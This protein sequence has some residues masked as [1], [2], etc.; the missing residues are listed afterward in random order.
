MQCRIAPSLGA[1][2]GHPNDVWGTTDYADNEIDREK[3][4][5]FFGLYGL[6][7]FYALWRHKGKK[8]ILWAGSDIQ[9]FINGYWLEEGGSIKVSHRPLATWIQK[10]CESWVENDVEYEALKKVGI[11]SQVCPSFM[12]KLSDYK[13]TFSPYDKTRVYTSVSGNDFK[14][15]EWDRIPALAIE[16]PDIEFHCYGNTVEPWSEEQTKELSKNIFLHG[17]VSK[18][19]MNEEIKY[20]SGALRLTKFDGFSEII[21]KSLLWGQWPVSLIPYPH[22]LQPENMGMLRI[23]YVPNFEG[24]KELYNSVNK[25]PWNTK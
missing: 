2:E 13:I 1:L 15:Y 12:G 5:V 11:E 24:R 9:H 10:N 20:M 17:R 16:H 23:A 21:A 25:Y 18:E 19:Q 22:T 7:D 6:P 4:A 8:Y 14:L 3:P